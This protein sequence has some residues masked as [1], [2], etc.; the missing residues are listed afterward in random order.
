LR[1][2]DELIF[3]TAQKLI[4]ISEEGLKLLNPMLEEF[5]G[6]VYGTLALLSGKSMGISGKIVWQ[7]TGSLGFL[8]TRIPKSIIIEEIRILLRAQ[9]YSEPD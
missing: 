8:T 2:E 1:K 7:I 5:G 3:I 4:N 9:D 6:K